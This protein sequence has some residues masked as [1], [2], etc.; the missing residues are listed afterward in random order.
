VAS[1]EARGPWSLNSGKP[2]IEDYKQ[3]VREG[4]KRDLTASKCPFRFAPES[5]LTSDIAGGPKSASKRLMHRSKL[6]LYSD[7][8]VGELK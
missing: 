7:H 2:D 1:V 6:R 5:G 8:L 4:A 3:H